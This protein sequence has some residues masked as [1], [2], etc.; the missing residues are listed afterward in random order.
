MGN[1]YFLKFLVTFI[2]MFILTFLPLKDFGWDVFI[3]NRIS[4]RKYRVAP[5]LMCSFLANK[6]LLTVFTANWFPRQWKSTCKKNCKT[7]I[8]VFRNQDGFWGQLQFLLMSGFV[9]LSPPH[10][11]AEIFLHDIYFII[12]CEI[13][14]LKWF[15][16]EY[17]IILLLCIVNTLSNI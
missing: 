12:N 13:D 17:H 2:C 3:Y 10:Q 8:S 6:I 7:F 16:W 15:I 11:T 4:L 5:G 1:Q 9:L 14:A